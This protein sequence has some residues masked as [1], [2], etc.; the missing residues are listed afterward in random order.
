MEH[1][2]VL[3]ASIILFLFVAG[4]VSVDVT[5]NGKPIGTA[6]KDENLSKVFVENTPDPYNESKN[7]WS[8]KK[9]VA[10]LDWTFSKSG[11]QTFTIK[12][13]DEVEIEVVNIETPK[14][15]IEVNQMIEKQSEVTVTS[16]LSMEECNDDSDTG[17]PVILEDIIIYYRK[18][19][20]MA[21]TTFAESGIIPIKGLCK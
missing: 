16:Y 1:T 15:T 8:G 11:K 4:C 9:P 7:Y 18:P 10:I 19:S 17:N 21:D 13:N 20:L 14:G 12:N 5:L 6:I 3:I 2:Q